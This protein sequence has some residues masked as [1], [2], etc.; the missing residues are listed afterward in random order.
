MSCRGDSGGVVS[1]MHE[2]RAGNA[3][4]SRPLTN[5]VLS[6]HAVVADQVLAIGSD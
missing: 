5:Q 3:A 6:S 4:K 1:R 2:R